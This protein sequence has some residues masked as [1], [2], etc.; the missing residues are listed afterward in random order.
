MTDIIA[1][2][3]QDKATLAETKASTTG[4]IQTQAQ[5]KLEMAEWK[6]DTKN[7]VA[8]SN[9]T[10]EK[11]VAEAELLKFENDNKETT[12]NATIAT[13]K[14]EKRAK[15]LEADQA[16]FDL[17]ADKK[18]KNKERETDINVDQS[19][20]YKNR[21]EGGHFS[22]QTEEIAKRTQGTLQELQFKDVV[23]LEHLE[24]AYDLLSDIPEGTEIGWSTDVKL[25]LY[26]L[27][28]QFNAMLPDNPLTPKLMDA[29]GEGFQVQDLQKIKTVMMA[30]KPALLSIASNRDERFTKQDQDLAAELSA[31]EGFTS[32]AQAQA[33]LGQ[34]IG[35]MR[36]GMVISD[37]MLSTKLGNANDVYR[38]NYAV[39]INGNVVPA[40]R[41]KDG[42]FIPF[43]PITGA[44]QETAE[45]MRTAPEGARFL[46]TGK[47]GKKRVIRRK[48]SGK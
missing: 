1:G 43:I 19:T 39:K 12:Y 48:A 20:I 2:T 37:V 42:N 34:M 14:E 35:L 26:S 44:S 31:V 5:K 29:L 32:V 45:I 11:A 8:V 17:N 30:V 15:K 10:A 28:A 41:D 36:D 27:G 40:P 24:Q 21:Q 7:R 25:G 46:L 22:A 38:L 47:D 13:T 23:A 3:K 18:W 16:E 4:R 9:A 6:R 33:A